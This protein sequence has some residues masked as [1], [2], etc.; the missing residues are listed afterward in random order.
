M[1]LAMQ[2]FDC[3]LGHAQATV[4]QFAYWLEEFVDCAFLYSMFHPIINDLATDYLYCFLDGL[5]RYGLPVENLN[6][7][8][9]FFEYLILPQ[10]NLQWLERVY[11]LQSVVGQL[12]QGRKWIELIGQFDLVQMD[13][14][15]SIQLDDTFELI[16]R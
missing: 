9:N 7:V 4:W 12:A 14:T 10:V 8:F 1:Q 5:A 16:A 3:V 11:H 6:T 13:D 15:K 2:V